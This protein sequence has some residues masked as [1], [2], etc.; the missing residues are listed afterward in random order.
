MTVYADVL[1]VT[2]LYVDFFLL[3]CVRRSLHL[4]VRNRRL[5]LGAA[6]G[7]ACSLVCLLPQQPLWLAL[8]WGGGSAALTTAAAFCPLSRRGFLRAFLCFWAFSFLLAG[9]FLVLIRWF[10]PRNLAV[11]GHAVYLDLSP[12]LLFLFT[13]AAYLVLWLFQKL[14]HREDLSHQSR[15]FL[16]EQI[17]K[18]VQIWARADTGNTLRGLFRTASSGLHRRPWERRSCQPGG[19][20]ERGNLP[21]RELLA[22]VPFESLGGSGCCPHSGR[23]RCFL[24]EGAGLLLRRPVGGGGLP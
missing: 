4:R 15:R 12:L 2:N 7:A 17:G 3:W 10:A 21:A 1:A 24:C 16:V 6:V 19:L 20:L 22:A 18:S 9:F 23:N 8:L 11:V 13:A 14:F 5:A